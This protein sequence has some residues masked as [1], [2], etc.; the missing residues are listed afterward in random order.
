MEWSEP[1]LIPIGSTGFFTI[2]QHGEILQAVEYRY[3]EKT[4]YYRRILETI[5]L[6]DREKKILRRGMENVLRE[7]R[8][9]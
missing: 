3:Y 4:G 7:E 2:Y 9:L 5:E 1:E 6:L 8:I